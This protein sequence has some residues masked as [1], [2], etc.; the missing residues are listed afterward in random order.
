MN[1]VIT[2]VFGS[3]NRGDALLVESL[4]NSIREAL[5]SNAQISGI[6][7]FPELEQS[8][9][10]DVTWTPPPARSYASS[11]LLRRLENAVRLVGTHT[12]VACGAPKAWGILPPINQ[13]ASILAIKNADLVISCAGGFLLDV[14]A[15]IIGNL[16][17]LHI[18]N[19]FNIP[20]IV[21]PQTIGPI[22]N[23]ALKKLTSSI[24]MKARVIC[25]RERYTHEFL[26][27][28][29]GIPSNKVVR[30]TDIAFEHGNVDNIESKSALHSLGIEQGEPFIG[31]TVVDWP[32]P[33]S[34]N[35]SL[36]RRDYEDKMVT[37][38]QE[39]YDLHGSR[40][41]IFNQVSSDLELA[42]RVAA[43]CGKAVV[44]DTADRSTPVMRGMIEE[45]H[46]F[47]GS[48]FHSCVFALLG[49]VPTASLA[50]TYKSTGIMED[51]GLSKRVWNIESFNVKDILEYIAF[52]FSNNK[53]ERLLIKNSVESLKF[54]RFSSIISKY[55][56]LQSA[57]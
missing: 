16:T 14:N 36:A 40:T 6:A 28:E 26:I 44:L 57:T 39:I 46:S 7:H 5:G 2:N 47:I 18:A 29:L 19:H 45:A 50:Y 8:H 54:P 53:N 11:K 22:H 20:F 27:N 41:L 37:L 23:D 21:A 25:A 38:F 55:S 3:T 24:L 9:L 13:R 32:F 12:Y 48:R 31:A 49:G 42:N 1:V 17:Q 30:T 56:D 34:S 15:S 4:H 52:S 51:L 35:P 33:N 43:R 10:P